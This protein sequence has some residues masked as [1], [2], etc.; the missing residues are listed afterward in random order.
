[1]NKLEGFYALQRSLLP[2]VPWKKYDMNSILDDRILW[3]IRCAVIKGDDQNL[4]RKV[5]VTANEAKEFADKLL[6]SL[7]E[8]DLVLFYPYFIADKSGVIEVAFDRIVI[9]S[10]KD[11]LWNLVTHNKKDVTIIM[12]EKDIYLDGEK[13]FLH[14]T[15]INEL[16]EYAKAIKRIFRTDIAEGKV[17]FLEWSYAYNSDINKNP[18]GKRNLIFYEIRSV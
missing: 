6:S 10:V 5:G 16:L 3:T 7:G 15:E 14:K 11:D 18:I 9:E 4:P 2:S 1:M 12:S 17:F 8:Y 13:D